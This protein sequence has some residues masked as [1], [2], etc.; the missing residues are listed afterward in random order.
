MEQARKKEIAAPAAGGPA[1]VAAR[2]V[3]GM[4]K[5]TSGKLSE[6]AWSLDVQSPSSILPASPELQRGEHP[7]E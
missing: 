6:L 1:T 5:L 3:R 2:P 4:P 7:P